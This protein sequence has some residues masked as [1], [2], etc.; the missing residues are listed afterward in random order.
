MKETNE[1]KE[2][3]A[4]FHRSKSVPLRDPESA[5]RG[6]ARF[7]Q[8]AVELKPAVSTAP[9]RRHIEWL[10]NIFQKERVPM[11]ATILVIIGLLMGGS[12]ATVYASQ[13]SMPDQF[14]YP[15][16]MWSE[17][18]RSDF[19][20]DPEQQYELMLRFA[21]ERVDEIQL[22]TQTGKTPP[23]GIVERLRL[24]LNEC[25]RLAVEQDDAQ[26]LQTLE[27]LHT[28]LQLQE[29]KLE[30]VQNQLGPLDGAVLTRARTLLQTRLQL[31][32]A[33]QED[34][35]AFRR[36]VRAGVPESIG[37]PQQK[38]ETRQQQFQQQEP[39]FLTEEDSTLNS[40]FGSSSGGNPWTQETPTP[41][42]SYGSG[43]EEGGNPWTDT[44]PTP[45]SGYGSGDQTG[46]TSSDGCPKS[47]DTSGGNDNGSGDQTGCTSP[48]G[49]PKSGSD[50]GG[51]GGSGG[52]GKK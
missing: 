13:A 35:Q 21:E 10:N 24:H 34:P 45:G 18:V 8:Q 20:G 31:T 11:F 52:S 30:Q 23:E 14:L 40:G 44:T 42:S 25:F 41:G 15:V 16:K 29:Q 26:M 27:R 12:S 33:A 9:K 6:R 51:S 7:L 38:Q 32:A 37:E 48:D 50:S 3:Q 4:I 43:T 49:C 5:A 1:T 22:M 39:E 19:S 47:G 17:Q 28:R 2:I 46:C 36:Q